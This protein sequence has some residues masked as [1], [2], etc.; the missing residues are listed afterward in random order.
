MLWYSLGNH[1]CAESMPRPSRDENVSNIFYLN[2]HFLRSKRRHCKNL[3]P[4]TYMY[5]WKP[6]KKSI[7]D[8]ILAFSFIKY[9]SMLTRDYLYL[10]TDR[11]FDLLIS[12]AK[13]KFLC[14]FS[15]TYTAPNILSSMFRCFF[16]FLS[17]FTFNGPNEALPLVCLRYSLRS[18][19]FHSRSLENKFREN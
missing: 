6:K 10:I 18:E 14:F 4:L 2:K 5:V 19:V 17:N 16:S 3:Q 7:D 13:V 11:Y 8:P 12:L 9:I 1:C 15:Y